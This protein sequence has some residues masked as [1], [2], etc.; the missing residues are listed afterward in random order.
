M[1]AK[2]DHAGRTKVLRHR[3]SGGTA[4]RDSGGTAPRECGGTAPRECGGTAPRE[5]GGTALRDAG[6]R[7]LRDR[8]GTALQRCPA[9]PFVLFH[10]WFRD[11]ERAGELLPEAMALAT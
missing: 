8:G 6:G 5:C 2:D 9:D 1:R 10:K 11:A 3:Y 7:A 4:P